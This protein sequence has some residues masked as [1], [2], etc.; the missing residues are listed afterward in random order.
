[1]KQGEWGEVGNKTVAFNTKYCCLVWLTP[2]GGTM[3]ISATNHVSR[4]EFG[5]LPPLHF[6][7]ALVLVYVHLNFV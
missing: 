4:L 3:N 2:L 7:F 1:M 5:L 6:P